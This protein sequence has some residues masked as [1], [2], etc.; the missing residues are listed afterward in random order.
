MKTIF[1]TAVLVL[2]A[3]TTFAEDGY[4]KSMGVTKLKRGTVNI[5]TGGLELPKILKQHW[6]EGGNNPIK[7]SVYL[8]GG[9]IKGSTFSIG[10]ILS[11]VWDVVTLNIDIPGNGEPLMKPDYVWT[12]EKE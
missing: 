9:L 11:G 10:R 7:K 8:F 3:A 6:D 5:L 4:L 1:L 12:D 2:F